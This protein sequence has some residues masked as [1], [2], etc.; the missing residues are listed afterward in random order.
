MKRD[1]FRY[2][3]WVASKGQRPAVRSRHRF[4][5]VAILAARWFA[6]RYRCQAVVSL[7]PVPGEGDAPLVGWTVHDGF[8]AKFWRVKG[9][10]APCA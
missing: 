3:L 9:R 4:L 8:R 10:G 6:T 2:Y 7:P 1:R 5:F